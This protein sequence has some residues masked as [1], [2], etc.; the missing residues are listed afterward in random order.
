LPTHQQAIPIREAVHEPLV[1][2]MVIMMAMA[3]AMVMVMAMAMAMA[4][5]RGLLF[6]LWGE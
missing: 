2:M 5:Y 6:R 4:M 1:I 3:I